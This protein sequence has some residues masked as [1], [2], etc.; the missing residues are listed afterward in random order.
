METVRRLGFVAVAAALLAWVPGQADAQDTGVAVDGWGGLAFPAS[1]MS[2][3]QDGGPS[4]GLG[5][6]YLLTDRV[7]VRGSGAVDLMT[8]R[9][10]EELGS[11]GEL[12]APDMTL[13]HYTAGLGVRL[14]PPEASNWDIA[15]SLEVGATSISTDDFPAGAV[16]PGQFVGDDEE[17]TDEASFSATY[18]TFSPGLRVG[19]TI[20]DRFGVFLRSQPHFVQTDEDETAAF[21]QFAAAIPGDLN[22]PGVEDLWNVPLTAGIQVRF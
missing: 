2:D 8:G 9:D 1:T 10:A 5:L 12:D 20:Q 16:P 17:A 6:E 21:G 13:F 18:L 15:L 11:P 4:F 19:Y 7:F 14:V 22:N 3:F